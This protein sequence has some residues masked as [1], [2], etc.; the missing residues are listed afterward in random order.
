MKPL[1][2]PKLGSGLP[3][4][5]KRRTTAELGETSPVTPRAEGLTRVRLRAEDQYP[6]A[7]VDGHGS[8]REAQL[9]D[10]FRGRF[11]AEHELAAVAEVSISRPVWEEADHRSFKGVCDHRRAVA[12]SG[13]S[14][15]WPIHSEIP[16]SSA[17]SSPLQLS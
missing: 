5:L 17:G 8:L 7:G 15:P 16:S 14:H 13:R 6:A 1:P 9:F 10:P 11:G 2:S 3:S 12:S 4:A